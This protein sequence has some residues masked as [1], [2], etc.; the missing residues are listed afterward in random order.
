MEK[1]DSV[2]TVTPWWIRTKAP[3]NGQIFNNMVL[4][5]EDP[6]E[7]RIQSI[8]ELMVPLYRDGKRRLSINQALIITHSYQATEGMHPAIRRA[9]ATRKVFQEL[10]IALTPLQL[11]MGGASSG[12]HIVDFTPTFIPL[13]PE[14]WEEEKDLETAFR[15]AEQRYVF[16]VEDQD[17]FVNQIWPYWKTRAR[18][19]YFFNELRDH[20]PEAWRFMRYAQTARYSPLIGG[21]LAHSL[22]DYKSILTRG[23][24]AIKA[25]IQQS[26][27]TLDA[28]NPTGVEDFERRNH[29]EAMLIVADGIIDYANRNADLAQK[30]AAEEQDSQRKAELLE[31][32][33]ICRKV[34]A[35]PAES[36]WEALQAFH[37]LRAGTALSEGAD[38][39]SAGRFDQYM[40]S[41]LSNDLETGKLNDKKAQELL[42]CLF[43]KWNETRAFK[44]KLSVGS[45]G[46]GNNDK[47]NIGGMDTHGNDSTNFLSYRILEALAHVHLIDPNISLR[48]HRNTPD[49]FLR[50]ALE[51]VRLGGGQPILIN[52]D[53]IVPSLVYSFGAKLEHARNYGDVGCQ[54]NNIDPN[55]TGVDNNGRNNSGWINLP[56]PIELAMFNGVNPINGVQIGPQTGDPRTFTSMSQFTEAVRTQIEY[57]VKMNALINNVYDYVF[58][59]Y[60]PCVY[61]NLMYPGPRAS[62]I[63]INAGGCMYNSTGCLA[64]GI[65]N[66]GDMMSAI[67]YLV[68][69]RKDTTWDEL[70]AALQAD[71]KGYEKLHQACVSAPKYGT[72]NEYADGWVRTMLGMYYNAYEQY[73][74]THHG[75]F[76]VGLLSM[77]NYVPLGKEM[78]A[79]P[80]GRKKGDPLAD[81]TSPSTL[82]P[83]LGPTAT[84]RSAARAIDAYHTPNGV[85][86][87][88]R[89][90][91]GSLMSQR[92]LS[93][94]ADLVRSYM[95]DGG[96]EVQ[97]SILDGD[98]LKIAQQ[99]PEGFRDLLVRVGGYSAVFVE[100]SKDVQDSIIARSELSI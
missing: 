1:I 84:H 12:P 18:E 69:Q 40:L 57:A 77:G 65:A 99:H 70:L 20:Y 38:S 76:V 13:S 56:K 63:D 23:L 34:P 24:A 49:E 50:Q 61:H 78:G 33:R 72:D 5:A 75:H 94:W 35:H 19:I 4:R 26:I 22:Q 71:W 16:E 59:R 8:R 6:E 82:A 44:L 46:G 36:W 68:Y 53:V 43:L 45:A 31:M 41:Y 39:H 92:E 27:E 98:T 15:G 42:E 37:F 79:T 86:F 54:E 48:M 10:P 30:L 60:F 74:T 55:M 96:M 21:G 83:V 81:S 11:F 2:A 32:A 47:L 66:L 89:F 90:N 85:T 28:S 100:L 80:D 87:N 9:L 95:E 88:Q 58:T 97:Y 91:A 52:D 3:W 73:A 64:V 14:E 62:G 29:Y 25:D 17:I 7:Q 67:D 51:V 93:K